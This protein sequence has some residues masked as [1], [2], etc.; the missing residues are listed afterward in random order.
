MS[1]G[2]KWGSKWGQPAFPFKEF[3]R[4]KIWK[5]LQYAPNIQAFV[6]ILADCYAI[7]DE[8]STAVATKVGINSASGLELDDWGEMVGFPR[9]GADDDLYRRAI[10]A[11]ARR[12]FASGKPDDFYDIVNALSPTATVRI[13]EVF[14]ACMIVWIQSASVEESRIIAKLLDGVPG[15]GICAIWIEAE[16]Q[17]FTWGHSTEAIPVEYSWDHS[18][19]TIPAD[20]KAGMAK[21][22]IIQ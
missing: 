10:K 12:L 19:G 17:V 7:V 6:D 8:A 4:A 1:W 5:H 21:A 15:L 22:N 14:P 16:A 13:A 2:D 11:A 3:G 20:E 18:T 9:N